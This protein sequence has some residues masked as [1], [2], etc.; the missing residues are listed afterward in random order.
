MGEDGR[1]RGCLASDGGLVGLV[2]APTEWGAD[3]SAS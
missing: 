1:P 2:D 3:F